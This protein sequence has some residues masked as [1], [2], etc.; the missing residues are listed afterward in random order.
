MNC[1]CINPSQCHLLDIL[2]Y[3][4][5]QAYE[6]NKKPLN[7]I[8]T[9]GYK[10]VTDVSSHYEASLR[11]MAN[12]MGKY[13]AFSWLYCTSHT[14]SVMVYSSSVAFSISDRMYSQKK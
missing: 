5:F 14:C 6:K 9:A 2:S 8:K 3:E 4:R 11:E 7:S 1:E 10:V 13:I 12:G